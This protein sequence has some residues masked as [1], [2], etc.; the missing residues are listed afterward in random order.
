M[1][2]GATELGADGLSLMD[3][4]QHLRLAERK[5]EEANAMLLLA[6]RDADDLRLHNLQLREENARLRKRLASKRN[7]KR[8]LAEN[9]DFADG[10]RS[11][12][13]HPNRIPANSY[14]GG[15]SL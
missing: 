9:A 12:R 7:V 14:P 3:A 10:S 13:A 2:D 15:H 1:G 6:Q 8:E 11:P 5:E 4:E